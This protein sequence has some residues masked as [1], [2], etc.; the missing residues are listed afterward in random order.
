MENAIT[1]GIVLL[2]VAGVGYG[3]FRCACG[4]SDC[5]GCQECPEE[6]NPCTRE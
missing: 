4:K 6:D 1:I 5:P 2:A 3:M